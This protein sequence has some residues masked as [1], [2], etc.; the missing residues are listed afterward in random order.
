VLFI[1]IDSFKQVNDSIGHEGGDRLLAEVAGR[2]RDAVRVGDVVGRSAATSS[3]SCSSC[4][5][6][7][8]RRSPSR[9]AC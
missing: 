1:D 2:L 9:G 5:R 7:T 6:T 3:R 8:S 4:S